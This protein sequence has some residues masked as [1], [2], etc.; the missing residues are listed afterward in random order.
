MK[1][2]I[3]FILFLA[4]FIGESALAD[5]QPTAR[6][7]IIDADG[8]VAPTQWRSSSTWI[9]SQNHLLLQT[10]IEIPSHIADTLPEAMASFVRGPSFKGPFKLQTDHRFLILELRGPSELFKLGSQSLRVNIDFDHT[11]WMRNANCRE[12]NVS[13]EEIQDRSPAAPNAFFISLFCRPAKNGIWVEVAASDEVTLS[14][15]PHGQTRFQTSPDGALL[16]LAKGSPSRVLADVIVAG[17][18]GEVSARYELAVDRP[19]RAPVRHAATD[20]EPILLPVEGESVTSVPRAHRDRAS[21]VGIQAQVLEA[22]GSRSGETGLAR[23]EI[24]ATG[25]GR[26]VQSLSG[27]FAIPLRRLGAGLDAV[28]AGSHL[29]YL[30]FGQDVDGSRFT[31]TFGAQ[32]TLLDVRSPQ[33]Q[34]VFALAPSVSAS[35]GSLYS[36]TLAPIDFI[37]NFSV[38]RARA[39]LPL[40]SDQKNRLTFEALIGRTW[41]QPQDDSW[42]VNGV[43][44]GFVGEF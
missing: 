43:S 14:F 28:G 42:N 23:T 16:W 10:A 41:I 36:I 12:A 35:Y 29:A 22:H 17:G 34:S 19:E 8:Q 24:V 2:R 5:S 7:S 21:V 37:S 13:L 30:N 38:A 33:R 40:T 11:N 32:A 6:I 27:D 26:L 20:A 44:V 39:D 25:R 3:G 18:S 1:I 4:L 9:W 15:E 31:W